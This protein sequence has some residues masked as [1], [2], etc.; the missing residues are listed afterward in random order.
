MKTSVLFAWMREQQKQGNSIPVVVNGG[1]FSWITP[2]DDVDSLILPDEDYASKIE[3]IEK[4]E[5]YGDFKQVLDDIDYEGMNFVCIKHENGY[6][7]ENF[8][9]QVGVW[10]LPHEVTDVDVWKVRGAYQ[11]M[12]RADG[13]DVTVNGEFYVDEDRVLH[14]THIFPDGEERDVTF[15]FEI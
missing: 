7:E 11:L 1:G 6:N 9:I 13:E 4:G 10:D 2:D 3:Y 5:E 15:Q 12:Y 8:D 14:H